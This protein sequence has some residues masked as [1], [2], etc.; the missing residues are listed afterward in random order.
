MAL[1]REG[2]HSRRRILHARGDSTGREIV[3]TLVDAA[4]RTPGIE[5]LA[6]M[7]SIDLLVAGGR[8]VGL[9]GLDAK[10]L[11]KAIAAILDLEGQIRPGTPVRAGLEARNRLFTGRLIADSALR[12]EESRGSHFREDFP[13]TEAGR[14][15]HSIIAPGETAADLPRIP[16]PEP[17]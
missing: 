8:C 5:L 13:V 1:G 12:R 6:Q 16:L 11:R 7:F 15:R 10:G 3:R 14:G 4:R 17:P 9:L 2:A